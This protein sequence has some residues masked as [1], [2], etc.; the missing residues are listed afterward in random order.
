MT[1]THDPN[2]GDF[3]GMMDLRQRRINEEQL[4]R[5]EG[6]M[7]EIFGTIGL[8]IDT[9]A[10]RETPRRYLC[11]PFLRPGIRGIHSP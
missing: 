3:T 2:N 5:F 4:A 7:A 8:D 6:Y 11:A 1:G 10:T 9:P